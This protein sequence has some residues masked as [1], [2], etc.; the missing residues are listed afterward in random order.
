MKLLT[1][2][3]LIPEPAIA[4]NPISKHLGKLVQSVYAEEHFPD[5][6][7]AYQLEAVDFYVDTRIKVDD[8]DGS[9]GSSTRAPSLPPLEGMMD[10]IFWVG[11]DQIIFVEGVYG[12]GKSTFVDY[13][14]RYYCPTLG[15]RKD[16][17]LKKLVVN[18][19]LRD[20][21]GSDDPEA[22]KADF[23]KLLTT[24]LNETAKS[25]HFD[26]E[27]HRGKAFFNFALNPEGVRWDGLREEAQQHSWTPEKLLQKMIERADP[28]EGEDWFTAACKFFTDSRKQRDF[29][30][31]YFV[32]VLD[33]LDQTAIGALEVVIK[34]V[35]KWFQEYSDLIWRVIIP[36]RPKTLKLLTKTIEPYALTT[37]TLL[38]E[39]PHIDL[40]LSRRE[41][42][43]DRQIDGTDY[44]DVSDDVKR[45]ASEF[46]TTIHRW[47][48][49]PSRRLLLNIAFGSTRVALTMWRNAIQNRLLYELFRER[50]DP[51]VSP[52]ISSYYLL[53]GILSGGYEGY[54]SEAQPILNLFDWEVDGGS[55]HD[56][57]LAAHFV[58][59]LRV[60]RDSVARVFSLLQRLGYSD[61]AMGACLDSFEAAHVLF[62]RSDGSIET[63]AGAI[64]GY[65]QLLRHA[66]YIDCM[67]LVTPLGSDRRDALKRPTTLRGDDA[68][69]TR[70]ENGTT[71]LRYIRQNEEDFALGKH[72]SKDGH[73]EFL[74]AI[75]DSKLTFLW[76]QIGRSY[77]S[78]I[79]RLK[80]DKR[81]GL[82]D[83]EWRMFLG[84]EP[85]VNLSESLAGS[86]NVAGDLMSQYRV[87]R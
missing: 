65:K 20:L 3:P 79:R 68:F 19:S 32:I 25:R 24:A 28:V 41:V 36:V 49:D 69:K 86:T 7:H 70:L 83:K 85:L 55:P 51:A 62:K 45:D 12:V 40:V 27:R 47:L 26:I 6:V 22:I 59:L 31:K 81:F 52:T 57:L 30:F 5:G 61:N 43:W 75:R 53:Y 15:K 4:R 60:P 48:T 23:F 72:I 29:P 18:V 87:S 46:L 66:A 33:N 84:K 54:R 10:E 35:K 71:F 50:K 58:H 80:R 74:R 9:S 82:E 73:D 76:K 1:S 67:S 21:S 64:N 44:D 42:L 11:H 2:R 14:L 39:P 37:V 17:F 8:Y 56:T 34:A 38:L 78:D 13:Y 63:V 77:R 16:D